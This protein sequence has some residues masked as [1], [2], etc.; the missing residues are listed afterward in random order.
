MN[1]AGSR[2]VKAGVGTGME[3]LRI[4]GYIALVTGF[5]WLLGFAGMAVTACDARRAAGIDT[6]P[7]SD[8]VSYDQARQAIGVT[9]SRCARADREVIFPACLMLIGGLLLA[10]TSPAKKMDICSNNQLHPYSES[11]GGP[12]QG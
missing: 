3:I 1:P 10:G 6:L 5:V 11:R 8:T 4:T 12:P 2:P 7:K 9:A